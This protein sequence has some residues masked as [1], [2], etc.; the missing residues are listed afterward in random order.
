MIKFYSTRTGI[1]VP[2]D[3]FKEKFN[4][5]LHFALR[6]IKKRFFTYGKLEEHTKISNAIRVY[7]RRTFHCN[8]Y[9]DEK[10]LTYAEFTAE[11]SIFWAIFYTAVLVLGIGLISIAPEFLFLFVLYAIIF[12]GSD[13]VHLN[14]S[15]NKLT[16]NCKQTIEQ[17]FPEL[18][19]IRNSYQPPKPSVTIPSAPSKN[20]SV[21]PPSIHTNTAPNVPPPIHKPPSTPPP[22]RNVDTKPPP[23]KIQ[24]FVALN[25]KQMG[26][27][28]LEKIK[29]LKEVGQLTR[30]TLVWKQG[31]PEWESAEKIAEIQVF[32]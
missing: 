31:M 30:E 4:L 26:P 13:I 10:G 2:F 5:E 7:E 12:F 32:F 18:T 17:Y 21:T 11:L 22:I 8:Y 3:L 25:G 14:M 24:F 28:D 20:P 1:E 29:L 27:Y 16:R 6:G 23:L 15:R 9:K 19:G